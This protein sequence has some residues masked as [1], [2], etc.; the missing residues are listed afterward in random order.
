VRLGLGDPL[1]NC[2]QLAPR[3]PLSIEEVLALMGGPSF[4]A[5]GPSLFS[6]GSPFCCRL[7]FA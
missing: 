6:V 1:P 2:L 4:H 7:L 3:S 5:I